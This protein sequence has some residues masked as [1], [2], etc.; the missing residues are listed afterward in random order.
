MR[1]TLCTVLFV[2]FSFSVWS[3]SSGDVQRPFKRDNF[4][5]DTYFTQLQ[6]LNNTV[7]YKFISHGNAFSFLYDFDLK[8]KRT[9]LAVGLGYANQN[10]YTN[11]SINRLD[12]TVGTYS[13][14]EPL[15][16]G[17]SYQTNKFKTNFLTVPFEVRLRG[18]P[19][20]KQHH[21]KLYM[22]G[23]LKFT[24]NSFEKYNADGIKFKDLYQPD[25]RKFGYGV[26]L[27]A[28][29]ARFMLMTKYSLSPVFQDNKGE[30]VNNLS[31]GL[32]LI[33]F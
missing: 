20:E 8:S 23:Y 17:T 15:P 2:A 26:S 32:T 6:G 9:S 33:P 14:F 30:V 7:D 11:A 5:I 24:M 10:Y 18:K 16:A 28:G 19:N 27:R 21:W 12:T 31:F 29:Y 13:V 3:Q 4:L 1:K 25:V 22:G